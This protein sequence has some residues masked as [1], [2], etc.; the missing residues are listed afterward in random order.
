LVI[1]EYASK[2]QEILEK[3][4]QL[5]AESKRLQAMIVAQCRLITTDSISPQLE[6]RF[7]VTHLLAIMDI[8]YEWCS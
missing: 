6:P 5:L 7:L 4:E 8:Y 2:A 1:R 3:P